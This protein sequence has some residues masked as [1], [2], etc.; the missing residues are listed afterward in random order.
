[1]KEI[2]LTQGKVALV[3]DGDFEWLMRYKWCAY[4][5]KGFWYAGLCGPHKNRWR[6]MHVM[7]MEAQRFGGEVVHLDHDGLNNQRANLWISQH[8]RNSIHRRGNRVHSSQYKGVSWASREGKWAAQVRTTIA[9]EKQWRKLFTDEEDA[10]RAYDAKAVEFF[11]EFA[12][13]NFHDSA[14]PLSPRE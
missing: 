6:R 5:Q 14:Q 9:P 7:V 10:A 11:G 2:P 12:Y 1:M 13:L 4:N 8:G 3:D